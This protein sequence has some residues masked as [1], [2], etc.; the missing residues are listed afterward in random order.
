MDSVLLRRTI[1][2]VRTWKF[3]TR[4]MRGWQCNQRPINPPI[5]VG[6]PHSDAPRAFFWWGHQTAQAAIF[7][8]HSKP[9]SHHNIC[10]PLSYLH[11]LATT[12]FQPASHTSSLFPSFSYSSPRW[13]CLC[14]SSHRRSPCTLPPN[15][16]SSSLL[17]HDSY[18]VLASP[19]PSIS[20]I[21]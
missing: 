11:H 21:T 6:L 8:I 9:F 5:H 20:S 4:G 12:L 1:S 3:V 10:A 15:S 19:L 13:P 14:L 7:I 17:I 2:G 16:S 18:L